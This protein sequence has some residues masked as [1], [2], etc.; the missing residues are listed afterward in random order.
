MSKY[1][2]DFSYEKEAQ[3]KAEMHV[4]VASDARQLLLFSGE[5]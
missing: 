5:A 1:F 4:C 3:K 2:K